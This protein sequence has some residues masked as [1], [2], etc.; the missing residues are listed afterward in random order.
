MTLKLED[1]EGEI[2]L[3][4][5]IGLMAK[6]QNIS[7][8]EFFIILNRDEIKQRKS[9]I[10]IGVYSGS[11]KIE[12]IKTNFMGPSGSQTIKNN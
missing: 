2:K 12:T 7:E 9:K 1:I 4:G 11:E 3:V 10:K 6:K 8:G 5:S